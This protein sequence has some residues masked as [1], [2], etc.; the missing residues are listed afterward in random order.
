MKSTS[1]GYT[2]VELMVAVGLFALIMTLSAGSYV[3]M[4][5]L[6][7]QVQ[8]LTLGTNSLSFALDTMLRTIRSG[9]AY[10]CNGIGDCN[11]A[12]SFSFTDKD[13]N[14]ITYRLS[15]G[16]IQETIGSVNDY[17]TDA[18]SVTITSLT[19]Y[20]YG[21]EPYSTGANKDQARVSITVTGI[22]RYGPNKT[23]N[24]AIETGATMRGSDL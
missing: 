13:G 6:N 19:F 12:G 14:N 2:L 18:S 7:R 1:S 3:M 5:G 11:G 17:L 16:A 22:I 10:N 9:S 24:F 4:I 23:Q 8:A 21:T 20:A 15:G